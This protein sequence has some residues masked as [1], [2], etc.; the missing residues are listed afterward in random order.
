MQNR[1]HLSNHMMLFIGLAV[2]GGYVLGLWL[3]LKYQIYEKTLFPLL[4]ILSG[5]CSHVLILIS[6]W[7]LFKPGKLWYEFPL[8]S[9]V[10]DGELSESY[11][12]RP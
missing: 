5:G 1:L 3:N 12:R 8:C 6:R 2:M 10:S 7:I 11:R 9:P 4:L